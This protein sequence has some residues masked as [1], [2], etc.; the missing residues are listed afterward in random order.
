MEDNSCSL[1][2]TLP[3]A[4]PLFLAIVVFGIM[5]FDRSW[6]LYPSFNHFDWSFFIAIAALVLASF[7]SLI[8]FS[9]ARDARQ[10]RKKMHNLV[11]N[12][13]PRS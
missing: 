13:Q 6:L 3:T 8:L 7:C 1:M 11:Y 9:E 4:V 12:M 2:P 10:R 5:A